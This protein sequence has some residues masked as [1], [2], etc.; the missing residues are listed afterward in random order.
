MKALQKKKNVKAANRFPHLCCYPITLPGFVSLQKKEKKNIYIYWHFFL[1]FVF[2]FSVSWFLPP[3]RILSKCLTR[4]NWNC[5]K[6]SS[7]WQKHYISWVSWYF[8]LWKF[9]VWLIFTVLYWTATMSL[10]GSFFHPQ[11]IVP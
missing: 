8:L 2:E 11:F 6:K 10:Y 7:P 9:A 1:S 4:M 3:L 5:L